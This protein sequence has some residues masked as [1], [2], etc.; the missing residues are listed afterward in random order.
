MHLHAHAGVMDP[1]QSHYIDMNEWL[2]FMLA[3]DQDLEKSAMVCEIRSK[4]LVRLLKL[5]CCV[6]GCRMP[7]RSNSGLMQTRGQGCLS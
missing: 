3:T 1:D 2:D 5:R 4:V 7:T 6:P